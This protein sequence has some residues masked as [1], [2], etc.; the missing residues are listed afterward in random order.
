MKSI[1]DSSGESNLNSVSGS[2]AC[3]AG[4]H[5]PANNPSARIHL[6]STKRIPWGLTKFSKYTDF[7]KRNEQPK[8]EITQ[9]SS[10]ALS[11]KERANILRY[12]P[13]S[14]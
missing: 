11:K 14:D 4:P 10:S 7:V 3:S 13:F 9:N 12:L 5:A 1:P 6:T 2:A 8:T